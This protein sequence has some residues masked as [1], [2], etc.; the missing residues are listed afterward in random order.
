M[1]FLPGL[2]TCFGFFK[3]GAAMTRYQ[4]NKE[5]VRQFAIEW[6]ADFPNHNHSYSD[7]AVFQDM[8]SRLGRKYGLL[9]E[10]RENGLI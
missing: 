10:F 2:L 4:K 5:E 1:S 7:L 3:G 6:Q 8:F 9:R